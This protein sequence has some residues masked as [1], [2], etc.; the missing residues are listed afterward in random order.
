[1]E[2]SASIPA[3]SKLVLKRLTPSSLIGLQVYPPLMSWPK[4]SFNN[5]K[6]KM[7]FCFVTGIHGIQRNTEDIYVARAIPVL[8]IWCR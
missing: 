4:N 7:F 5:S 3:V 1:M 8:N 2:S 6:K